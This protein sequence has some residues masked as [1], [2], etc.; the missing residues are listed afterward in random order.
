MARKIYLWF[1]LLLSLPL[2]LCLFIS[3]P[4]YN[5]FEI[6]MHL[7]LYI[8]L[9]V[10]FIAGAQWGFAIEHDKISLLF[11]SM[12]QF[13]LPWLLFAGLLEKFW[14]PFVLAVCYI[15]VIIYSMVIN[16][17]YHKALTR[18]FHYIH[19]FKTW[20]LFVLMLANII[21]L[22]WAYDWF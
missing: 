12:V 1:T 21:R 8:S 16:R 22:M 18:V 17:L 15:L 11:S 2:I 6:Q 14:P 7:Y 10:T 19:H 5:Q 3:S 20:V 4:Y 13:A 9:I